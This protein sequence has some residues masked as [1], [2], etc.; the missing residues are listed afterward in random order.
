[1]HTELSFAGSRSKHGARGHGFCDSMTVK[2]DMLYSRSISQRASRRGE[3]LRYRN[4][5]CIRALEISYQL[6]LL[7]E[8]GERVQNLKLCASLEEIKLM[9]TSELSMVAPSD[10]VE[11]SPLSPFQQSVFRADP[12][13]LL[14]QL[15]LLMKA[16]QR[17]SS[18][19]ARCFSSLDGG[20]ARESHQGLAN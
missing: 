15:K 3:E 12:A 20:L 14:Y 19:P 6:L 1:M 17:D 7:D 2:L 11:F 13:V 16:M 18:S 5:L 8:P 9:L 4:S 10:D